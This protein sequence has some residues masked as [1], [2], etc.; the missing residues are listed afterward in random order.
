M[1][2]LKIALP[3]LHEPQTFC[4]KHSKR[5][6]VLNCGRRWGK[7]TLAIDLIVCASKKPRYI[8]Y[9]APTYKML[10]KTWRIVKQVFRDFIAEKNEALKQITLRN[11]AIIEFWSLDNADSIRG[12]AYHFIIVDEVAIIKDFLHIWENSIRP[13]LADYVGSA[14][15]LSTPKGFYNDFY[16]LSLNAEKYPNE[17]VTF[18]MPTLSN[19][20]IRASEIES[21]KEQLPINVFRQEYEAEFVN[22]EGNVFAESFIYE[23][24]V[25]ENLPYNPKENIFISFDFNIVNTAVVFQHYDNTIFVLKEYHIKGWDLQRLC[26]EIKTDYANQIFSITGDASGNARSA[27]TSGNASAYDLIKGNMQLIGKNFNIPSANPSHLNSRLQT[28]VMLKSYPIKIDANCKLLIKDLQMVVCDKQGK[29]DKS[30][31]ELTHFLDA[32]RYYL[33]SYHYKTY[34]NIIQE[35][36]D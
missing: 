13:L 35:N 31:T 3:T 19:P 10:N 2:K 7:T 12:N 21:A 20:N 16:T 17:W 9:C 36:Y 18:K 26:V 29:I 11:G 22:Y 8:A 34:K 5:F 4:K 1:E 6:V 27:Y 33:W 15:F 24:H 14:W 28:N 30:D 32:F 25:F 23:K